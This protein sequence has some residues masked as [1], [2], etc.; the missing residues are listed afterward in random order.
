[1]NKRIAREL[2]RIAKG[3]VEAGRNP[4]EV[5]DVKDP[6]QVKEVIEKMREF[7]LTVER[8]LKDMETSSLA[9]NLADVNAKLN[10]LRSSGKA[11]IKT[12]EN[13]LI[14]EIARIE[15]IMRA[16]NSLEQFD[17][18]CKVLEERFSNM[19]TTAYEVNNVIDAFAEH[20]ARSGD[21]N[22]EIN[23]CRKGCWD[24]I[25]SIKSILSLPSSSTVEFAIRLGERTESQDIANAGMLAADNR[26]R[27]KK[28]G[29]G[30][31]KAS[32]NVLFAVIDNENRVVK[33]FKII[34]KSVLEMREH[35]NLTK[36][37]NY[38]DAGKFQ[39]RHDPRPL[40]GPGMR[41]SVRYK[42]RLARRR[43]A[44][45]GDLF[46]TIGNAFKDI[47]GN[48]KDF[49]ADMFTTKKEVE[50]TTYYVENAND[51]LSDIANSMQELDRMLDDILDLA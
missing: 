28:V 45:F 11:R 20:L 26:D 7:V 6:K 14:K 15:K 33:T 38:G 40:D 37:F 47:F 49:F 32:R 13:D 44:G 2:N 4:L 30:V 27:M 36:E 19:F 34:Q 46:D 3:L 12:K 1:M 21:I 22:A 9:K 48:I 16:A 42:N 24:K 25:N 8:D 17:D 31:M 39:P 43:E 10:E 29:A 5:Y 23:A 18:Q 50:K 41:A 51:A 35:I